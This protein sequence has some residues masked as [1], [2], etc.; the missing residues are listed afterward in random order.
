MV[1]S[2]F[3]P[4]PVVWIVL[5]AVALTLLGLTV[6]FSASAALKA[7]PMATLGKQLMGVA[8]AV[9]LA[10]LVSRLDLDY[11]RRHTGWIAGGLLLLL[12]I[13]LV[14]H[15]GLSV[16]GSRRWLGLGSLR[17]QV[18]EFAKLGMVFCLAHYVA[19]NQTRLGDWKRGYLYPL[20]IIAGFAGLVLAE[21]DFGTAALMVGVGLA[22]LFFAGAKWRH[23]IPTVLA[24]ALL[25]A[26]A[27]MHNPNRMRRFTA[28]RHVD[29]NR[30]GANYQLYESEVAFA[31]GGTYGVGLGRGR[32]QYNYL[33][34]AHNDYILGII[35]EELGLPFTM[36]VLVLFA[37]IFAAGLV[38]LRRAPNLFYSLLVAGCLLIV[39][40]QAMINF[41]SVTGVIPPKGMSLPFISA[42]LSNLL[43]M[44]LVVGVLINTQRTWGRARLPNQAQAMREVL[45]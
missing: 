29:E 40:L 35:A 14:P 25:F 19:L 20:A 44:G 30:A 32:Q 2:R 42:G 5:A 41:A 34:E 22:M 21:P 1:R 26:V 18:S 3:A 4:S 16:K 38:H 8:G 39:A 27:L 28:F 15:I 10:A 11:L 13:V 6:L 43:L 7:G 37:G 45:A 12:L 36:G 17:L 31:A 23:L 24:V 33:P 9:I